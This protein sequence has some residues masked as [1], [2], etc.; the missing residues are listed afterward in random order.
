[1]VVWDSSVHVPV[2]VESSDNHCDIYIPDLEITIHGSD[3]ISA[4]ANAV[5]KCSA[6]YYYNLER[7]LPFNI[8]KSYAEVEELALKRGKGCFATY[9]CL[10][11]R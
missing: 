11:D 9:M 2:I 1:M 6:I 7:N 3:Y 10:S 4:I 8:K 5:L